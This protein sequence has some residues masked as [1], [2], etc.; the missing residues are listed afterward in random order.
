MLRKVP[1]IQGEIYHIYNRGVDK[2]IIFDSKT[3]YQRF[4][5]LLYVAN[6]E[7]KVHLSNENDFSIENLLKK[8]RGESLVAIGSFCLMP[9]HFHLLLTPLV[10]NG[11]PK[12]MLKLQTAYSMYYNLKNNRSG[13]LFQG[14]F[15]AKHVDSDPYINH[16]FNYIHLNPLKLFDSD[17]Q[18][19]SAK[20]L[21]VFK[22]KIVNHPYSSYSEY[23]NNKHIITEPK[24][25]PITTNLFDYEKTVLN[26]LNDVKKYQG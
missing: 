10:D 2:R 21:L 24:K 22:D 15:K 4:L 26:F 5:S 6:G 14:P 8:D 1:F 13:S 16:L 11:I 18:N 20:D 12:F 3:D 7:N 17:W 25:F 9:N 19:K 23:L